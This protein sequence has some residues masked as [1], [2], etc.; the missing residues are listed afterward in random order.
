MWI[1]LL[2]VYFKEMSYRKQGKDRLEVSYRKSGESDHP[3]ERQSEGCGSDTQIKDKP[4]S[5]QGY[6]GPGAQETQMK[7]IEGCDRQIKDEPSSPQAYEGPGA[8]ESQSPNPQ[9][10]P[11]TDVPSRETPSVV[12]DPKGSRKRKKASRKSTSKEFQE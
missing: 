8:Q 10:T 1:S 7:G 5:P 2:C 6:E 12:K 4:S 9:E 3:S 11:G